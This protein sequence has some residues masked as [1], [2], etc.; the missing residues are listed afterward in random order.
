M[1]AEL[2]TNQKQ[3]KENFSFLFGYVL[4]YKYSSLKGQTWGVY[5]YKHEAMHADQ[6]KLKPCFHALLWAIMQ[7]YHI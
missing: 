5:M 3:K 2:W 1:N 6:W 7:N 4:Y